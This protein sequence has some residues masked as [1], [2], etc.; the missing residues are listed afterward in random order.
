MESI[1]ISSLETLNKRQGAFEWPIKKVDT[2]GSL[3]DLP[4]ALDS[5]GDAG[6]NVV[7]DGSPIFTRDTGYA[8]VFA[9]NV[10]WP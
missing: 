5:L 7:L 8:E 4:G 9:L 1:S 3:R 2:I 6:I 10:R